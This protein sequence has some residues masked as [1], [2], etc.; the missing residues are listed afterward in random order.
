MELASSRPSMRS[1][2]SLKLPPL[3]PGTLILDSTFTKEWIASERYARSQSSQ[4]CRL[5]FRSSSNDTMALLLTYYGQKRDIRPSQYAVHFS[6]TA[7]LS[8]VHSGA[9][10]VPWE[11]WGPRS[12]RIFPYPHGVMPAP[13]GPFWI[14]S[15]S[16]LIV[17]D[18]DPL[19]AVHAP[20]VTDNLSP[21]SGL[22]VFA[23]L[24]VISKCWASGQVETRLPY[25]EFVKRDIHI[26][27]TKIIGEREWVVFISASV[28]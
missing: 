5:P 10:S 18:Y 16:P 4:R 1:V 25:R 17:R 27:P 21:S 6:V 14:T 22:P 20:S 11:K 15:I 7:L 13:A 2:C 3:E 28:R 26:H 9:R 12:T 19:R 8:A 23:P 24:R